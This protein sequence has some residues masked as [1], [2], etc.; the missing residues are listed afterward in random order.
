M[1]ARIS[2]GSNFYGAA[3]YN[4][5]K[6]DKGQGAVIDY[7]G[8]LNTKPRTIAQTLDTYNNSRTKKPV[9]HASLSFSAKDRALLDDKKLIAITKDYLSEMGYGKQPYVIYRH[10]DTKHPHVHILTTRVDTKAGKR[11]PSYKEGIKSKAIT[12]QLELKYGLTIAETQQNKLKN[13]IVKDVSRVLRN[14]KPENVRNLNKGLETSESPVRASNSK[15]GIIFYKVD[16]NGKRTTRSSKSSI[17]KNTPIHSKTLQAQFEQNRTTRLEAKAIVEQALPKEGK[18]SISEFTKS[19]QEK[20]VTPIYYK[21]EKGIYGVSFNYQDHTYKGSALD[22]QLSF[23]NIKDRLDILPQKD[24]ALQTALVDK[25]K[26]GEKIQIPKSWSKSFSTNDPILDKALN[27]M[28]YYDSHEL[29]KIHNDYVNSSPPFQVGKLTNEYEEQLE[30][31]LRR[32]HQQSLT[33]GQNKQ[34][35]RIPRY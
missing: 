14:D 29:A 27:Q 23:G 6:I 16:E 4:Q 9:F 32:K 31:Y 1:I 13:A 8:L 15:R 10:D 22:R 21:S 5:Q 34:K 26:S 24:Q 12:E 19:L 30:E 18:I 11:I 28:D 25:F 2:A 17:F 3:N 7:K 33:K 35:L 20:G